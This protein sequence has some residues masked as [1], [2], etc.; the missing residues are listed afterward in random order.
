MTSWKA[1]DVARLL[2]NPFYVIQIAP[3]LAVEHEPLVARADWIRANA[4][5]IEEDG[6]ES[7]L[8]TL[9]SVLEGDYPGVEV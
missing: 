7:W 1:E 5:T 3:A 2:A 6:A 4:K 8:E 9:L